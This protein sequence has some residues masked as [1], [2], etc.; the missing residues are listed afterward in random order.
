LFFLLVN[1]FFLPS[2]TAVD[3]E[4]INK[5]FFVTSNYHERLNVPRMREA[6]SLLVGWHDF[7][8]FGGVCSTEGGKSGL[9]C[10]VV[11][12]GSR[13]NILFFHAWLFFLLN[14]PSLF[15]ANIIVILFRYYCPG[16]NYPSYFLTL[17]LFCSV[18]IVL[19]KIILLIS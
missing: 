6:L 7:T 9:R 3:Q 8:R 16:K 4:W 15:P 2:A 12:V 17:L 11:R 10:V 18:I 13:F 5:T 19:A 14:Y 1:F